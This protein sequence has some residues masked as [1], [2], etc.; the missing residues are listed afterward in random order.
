MS[1]FQK[2]QI[3]FVRRAFDWH[4]NTGIELYT[5]KNDEAV[6][7]ETFRIGRAEIR[8][9]LANPETVMYRIVPPMTEKEF[10]SINHEVRSWQS[11]LV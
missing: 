5:E 9:F 7:A 8:Q 10:A 6:F 4:G 1:T 11:G 2:H 3:V